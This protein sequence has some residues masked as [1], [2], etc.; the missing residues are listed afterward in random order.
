[1]HYAKL[2]KSPRLQRVLRELKRAKGPVTTKDLVT[3]A[4]VCAVNSIIAEL[5]EN[6]ADITCHQE[7]ENAERRFFYTLV[8]APEGW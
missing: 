7:V 4:N 2:S 1:M 6:G 3:S 5:R 8:K